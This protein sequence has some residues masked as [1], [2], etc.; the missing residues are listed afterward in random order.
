MTEREQIERTR[1]RDR[2]ALDFLMALAALLLLAIGAAAAKAQPPRRLPPEWVTDGE[3]RPLDEPSRVESRRIERP[4]YQPEPRRIEP[5]E[6]HGGGLVVNAVLCGVSET[7]WRATLA[8]ASAEVREAGGLQMGAV[9][10]GCPASF[11][12]LQQYHLGRGVTFAVYGPERAGTVGRACEVAEATGC[13]NTPGVLAMMRLAG[14]WWEPST[15]LHEIGHTRGLR[16]A[17]D[18]RDIMFIQAGATRRVTDAY[19][20]R[21]RG[22]RNESNADLPPGRLMR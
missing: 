8:A 14:E 4:R 21:L 5:R 19:L 7:Q 12:E 17:Q 20:R 11:A 2:I 18:P 16:H 15:I 9:S 3:F 13:A 1:Q 10:R 22:W 6:D